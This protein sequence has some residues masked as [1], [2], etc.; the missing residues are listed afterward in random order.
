MTMKKTQTLIL[1]SLFAVGARAQWAAT[2]IHPVGHTNSIVNMGDGTVAYGGVIDGGVATGGYISGGTF[3]SLQPAGATSSGVSAFDAAHQYGTA[4]F[5]GSFH[6]GRWSG[7]AASFED[8]N[9]TG[10]SESY[11]YTANNGTSGGY[12][13]FNGTQK[14]TVWLGGGG[15]DIVNLHDDAWDNSALDAMFGDDIFGD[16]ESGGLAHAVAWL[17]G[18]TNAVDFNPTG[19]NESQIIGADTQFQTGWANF[20]TG[21]H[22]TVWSGSA[23]SALDINPFGYSESIAYDTRGMAASGTVFLNNKSHAGYWDLNTNTFVDL[24]NVLSGYDS[25]AAYGMEVVN[26]TTY[27]YGVAWDT[28]AEHYHAMVWSQPV[29]EPA[30]LLVLGLGVA[31]LAR[32]RRVK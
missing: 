6:A 12:A 29:P 13:K 2:D 24:H 1:F 15:D 26:G 4:V 10:A 28:I 7:N 5:G 17:N 20:G 3:T 30:S 9:P 31:G 19:A 14:A 32:R 18:S 8:W 23:A 11:I 16:A 22:A 21:Y 25:S 27:V